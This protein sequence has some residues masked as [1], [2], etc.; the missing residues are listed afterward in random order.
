MN[1]KT[2]GLLFAAL[3]AFVLVFGGIVWQTSAG[4]GEE[5]PEAG[6]GRADEAP[7][8]AGARPS[9]TVTTA[10]A[11]TESWPIEL[12]ANGSV[13]AWQEVVVGSEINGLRLAEVLVNVG[14]RV[15]RGQLLARLSDETVRAERA[16]TAAMLAEAQ[17]TLSE[18]EANVERASRLEKSGMMSTQQ[19]AQHRTAAQTAQARVQAQRAR[20]QAGELRVANTRI[21]APDDGVISARGATM[22]SVVQPGAELFRLIRDA[23]LE[24]RAELPGDELAQVQAGQRVRVHAAGDTVEGRVRIVAPTVD[25]RTRMGIVYVD[26][27]APGALRAGVFARGEIE[28]GVSPAL[29]VAQSAVALRDGFAWVFRI[30]DDATVTQTKIS[31]GRRIGDRVEI[32]DGLSSGER[33]VE[34]GVGFL[35][36]GDLVRI[37][38]E[39]AQ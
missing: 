2:G 1:S 29:T 35:V 15:Q 3:L 28:L 26:L 32:V 34:S 9:L 39:A 14:D 24:W 17:A 27:P 23:R 7:P 8:S 12:V 10:V 18:A 6:R 13:A 20:L 4:N 5:F 25:P 38:P 30:G 33:I 36:D 37:V 22:G 19:S 31:L 11:R 16:Q 21:V